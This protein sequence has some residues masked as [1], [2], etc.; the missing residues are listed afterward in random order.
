MTEFWKES[1]KKPKTGPQYQA[2]IPD[3]VA[4]PRVSPDNAVNAQATDTAT[5]IFHDAPI[6]LEYFEIQHFYNWHQGPFDV[7]AFIAQSRTEATAREEKK[8]IELAKFQSTNRRCARFKNQQRTKYTES[9]PP[10]L[11]RDVTSSDEDLFLESSSEDNDRSSDEEYVAPNYVQSNT[12]DRTTRSSKRQKRGRSTKGT[13]SN[14]KSSKTSKTVK[15]HKSKKKSKSKSKKKSKPNR[16]RPLRD[17]IDLSAESTDTMNSIPYPKRSKLETRS[18][19]NSQ[20]SISN[21]CAPVVTQVPI[22]SLSSKSTSIQVPPIINPALIPQLSP[23]PLPHAVTNPMNTTN[24]MNTLAPKLSTMDQ[25]NPNGNTLNN[26]GDNT[27]SNA[28]ETGLRTG[29]GTGLHNLM[30]AHVKQQWD[31]RIQKD[32]IVLDSDSD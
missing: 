2:I 20:D 4:H 24:T 26:G 27:L 31:A 17:V 21:V 1:G 6:P 18:T 5:S 28:F 10:P 19:L 8:R 11:T 25:L 14:S 7:Q 12:T 32:V 23:M 3:L 13:K 9:S 30:M 29:L 16:K 15:K 22:P